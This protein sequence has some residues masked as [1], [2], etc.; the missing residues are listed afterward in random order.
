M[1]QK[2]GFES[3]DINQIHSY[4]LF[5]FEYEVLSVLQKPHVWKKSG[6]WVMVQKPVDQLEYRILWTKVF[7]NRIELWLWFFVCS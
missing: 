5:L 6:Y 1:D 4:V 3:F 2:W 7:L